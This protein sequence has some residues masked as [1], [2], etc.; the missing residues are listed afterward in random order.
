VQQVVQRGKPG[1]DR[2][3]EPLITVLGGSH[4]DRLAIAFE[5]EGITVVNLA[6]LSNDDSVEAK[7]KEIEYELS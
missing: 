7:K 4:A 2:S 5:D 1:T 6:N 3:E